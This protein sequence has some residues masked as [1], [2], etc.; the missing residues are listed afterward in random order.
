MSFRIVRL[1]AA[2]TLAASGVIG[3]TALGASGGQGAPINSPLTIVKTVSGPV[4]AGT[5]FTATVECDGNI[6][7]VDQG[8]D[9]DTATVTFD[10]TG[11]PTTAD[12]IS[13]KNQEGSCTVTET[14]TGGAETTTYSCESTLPVDQVE[15]AVPAPDPDVCDTAGPQS[16]PITV[17]IVNKDQTATVTIANTFPEPTPQSGPEPAADV[18]AT[19]HFTG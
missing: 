4:P 5:T 14:E 9:S 19:P 1:L 3:V 17:N 12:T 7:V 15:A 13:F 11:Q 2:T 18:V 10:A 6:I 8:P 16:D